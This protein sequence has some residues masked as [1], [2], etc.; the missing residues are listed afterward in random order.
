MP[1]R[2]MIG[3][4]ITDEFK[5]TLEKVDDVCK[6]KGFNRSQVI[7]NLLSDWV[8]RVDNVQDSFYESKVKGETPT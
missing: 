6:K 2:E 4:V 3:V 8:E 1:N 7:R 5:S